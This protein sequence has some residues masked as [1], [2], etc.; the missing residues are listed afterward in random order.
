MNQIRKD[1]FPK[2]FRITRIFLIKKICYLIQVIKYHIRKEIKI[3][4]YS[5]CR[6]HF[7]VT[8]YKVELDKT[9]ENI[10][11]AV[12]LENGDIVAARS[13]GKVVR[14]SGNKET[15]LL[16]IEGS[17]DW[18]SLWK[19]SRGNV[20]VSPHS[21]PILGKINI[22]ERGI[23]KLGV[24]G[25]SFCKVHSFYNRNSNLATERQ[26]NDDTVWTFC[27]DEEGALYAGVYAHTLRSNPSIY[28][29]Y[30]NGE[31]WEC[32]FNFNVAGITNKGRHIHGITYSKSDKNLYAIVGEVNNLFTSLDGGYHWKPLN[33]Y[34]ELAKGSALYPVEDGIIIGSDSAYDCVMSKYYFKSKSIRTTSRIWGSTIFA[35]RKSDVSGR[36]FAFSKIDS[37][38]NL[39]SYFPP[40]DAIHDAS[41]IREWLKTKPIH[42]YEWKLYN[43]SMNMG[44]YYDDSVRPQHIAI[45]MSDDNGETWSILYKEKTTSIGPNGFWT[46]GYFH[47]G[48]CL[49]GCVDSSIKYSSPY[50]IKEECQQTN[51]F[52]CLLTNSI[53]L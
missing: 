12:V 34:C 31:T 53:K 23:Y 36:L 39:L 16:Y 11:S 32:I 26:L 50:I 46:T 49:T 45:L 21:S 14:I 38:V 33:V 51:V 44:G 10:V 13:G 35:I 4:D 1:L 24:D 8:I 48:V 29:S 17:Q 30:D 15:T 27:E 37:S 40:K 47:K 3:K 19:D 41:Y 9:H 52:D 42:E 6:E 22:E 43:L 28:K 2:L 7:D 25:L 5:N 20:F 18:R